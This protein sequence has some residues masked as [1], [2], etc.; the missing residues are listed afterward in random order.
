MT[1]K[2]EYRDLIV[3]NVCLDAYA[4][5]EGF[6]GWFE[7]PLI[8]SDIRP[9]I[10]PAIE[11]FVSMF[12]EDP[13]SWKLV[14]A[15][16]P[17]EFKIATRPPKKEYDRA[18]A[19]LGDWITMNL[20]GDEVDDSLQ[21]FELSIAESDKIYWLCKLVLTGSLFGHSFFVSKTRKIITYT[22]AY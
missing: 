20:M 13:S 12:H 7:S 15:L 19:L 17:T 6:V 14:C 16:V 3:K 11:P 2:D 22:K 8:G 10:D 4:R 9:D 1:E 21:T 5:S 18:I